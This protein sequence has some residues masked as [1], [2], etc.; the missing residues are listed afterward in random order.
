MEGY[1]YII[2]KRK[3]LRVVAK[4]VHHL[5]GMVKKTILSKTLEL[6]VTA[7]A[8]LNLKYMVKSWKY[9]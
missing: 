8:F 6:N 5:D 2:L 3:R 7:S 9:N 1:Y 4:K